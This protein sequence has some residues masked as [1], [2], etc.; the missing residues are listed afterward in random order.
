MKTV[1]KINA[2]KGYRPVKD[3][4]KQ[5]AVKF[6]CNVNLKKNFCVIREKFTI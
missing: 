5:I 1:F 4:V 3:V 6:K 2:L